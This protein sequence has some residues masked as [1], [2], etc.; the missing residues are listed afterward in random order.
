MKGTTGI[1]NVNLNNNGNV[2]GNWNGNEVY[3]VSG[4]LLP[5]ADVANLPEGIY[6]I[7]RKTGKGVKT[8]K[9]VK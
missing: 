5:A 6:I 4:H 8:I 7:K 3:T 2:N 1:E 9:V